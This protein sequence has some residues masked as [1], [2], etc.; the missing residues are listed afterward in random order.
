MAGKGNY[1][2]VLK[3][4][5][6]Y[7]SV[8][9]LVS[10]LLQHFAERPWVAAPLW[11]LAVLLLFLYRDPTREVPALPLA[12][13]SPADGRITR[14]EPAHDP[15]LDRDAIRI[16]V[17][18]RFWGIYT[19]RSPTE[20]KIVER[21]TRMPGMQAGDSRRYGI[22]I[23]TDESD[24][25]VLVLSHSNLLQ[26]PQCYVNTGER[27]GQ[28]QRCGFIRFGAEVEVYVPANSKVNVEAGQAVRAG[29]D[30]I[31]TLVHK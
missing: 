1:S 12:V 30:V 9:L 7:A 31:A 13:I 4:G 5:W 6:L 20:G 21:W 8:V 17:Q 16:S 24:D 10:L 3:E 23:Q 29:V 18:M 25:V 27:I 15:Y 26:R 2:L 14:V 22:W 11:L 19:T 28:G